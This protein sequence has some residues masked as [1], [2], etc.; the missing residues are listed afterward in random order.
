MD[1]E[2]N[3]HFARLINGSRDAV[4]DFP[5]TCVEDKWL[6]ITL[7]QITDIKRKFLIWT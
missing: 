5:V 2:R 3:H 4:K 7:D 1:L 6:H